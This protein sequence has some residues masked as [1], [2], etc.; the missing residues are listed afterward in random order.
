[1]EKRDDGGWGEALGLMVRDTEEEEVSDVFLG[2]EVDAR[3]GCL[4][5]LDDDA[6]PVCALSSP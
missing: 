5:V 1:M 3:G 6:P 2:V 4:V